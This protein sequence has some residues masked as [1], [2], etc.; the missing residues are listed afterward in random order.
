M[1]AMIFEFT[2]SEEHFEEYMAEAAA[3]RPLVARIRGFISIERFESKSTP[4]KFVSIGFF[5]DEDAVREWRNLAEHRR[6]QHLGRTRLFDS[7]RLRMA[8]VL[9]DYSMHARAE[10]PEDSRLAHDGREE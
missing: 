9:R 1:I 4:G 7:Y 10:A 5:E 8:S 6:V 3:L 2:A